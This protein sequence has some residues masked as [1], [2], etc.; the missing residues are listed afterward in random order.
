VVPSGK[1]MLPG[2]VAAQPLRVPVA[3]AQKVLAATERLV[4]D[5]PAGASGDV[6][7]TQGAS[8]LLVHT[9]AVTIA[10]APGVVSVSIPVA[11]DQVPRGAT[12]VVPLAVGTA[13]RPAGLVMSSF[14]QPAGPASVTAVWAQALTAF[15]W[16]SLIH[17]AQE[18]AAVAGKD[19]AGRSLV[20]AEIGAEKGLLIVLPMARNELTAP[21]GGAP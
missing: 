2:A 7:W 4:A 14:T 17:L 15:A 1:K 3:D 9:G 18:L 6:V 20:P 19:H 5:L 10:C 8:E 13:A 16:E 21:A 12:V 11:C